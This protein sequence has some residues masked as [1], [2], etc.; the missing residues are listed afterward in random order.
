ML[1]RLV[2]TP[3]GTGLFLIAVVLVTG[4]LEGRP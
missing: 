3:V 2:D 4:W 1:R